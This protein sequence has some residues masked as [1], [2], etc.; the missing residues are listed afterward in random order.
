MSPPAGH[1][2][3]RSLATVARSVGR[4][5][6]L[7]SMIEVAAEEAAKAV[8][9]ASVSISRFEPNTHTVRVLINV[10]ELA[11]GE[12]RWPEQEVYRMED[13][14][15]LRTLVGELRMWTAALDDPASDPAEI[16]LLKS[17][18]KSSSMGAPLVVDGELWG[19]LYMTRVRGSDPF[20]DDDM[21]YAE[22]LAAIL[23]GALSRALHVDALSRLAYRD[24][25]TGL[26]NRRAFDEAIGTAFDPIAGRSG[27]RVSVVALDLNGLKA[28]NDRHGHNAGDQLLT[29]IAALLDAR[30]S[31]FPGSVVARVGGDEFAVLVPGHG[32]GG[33]VTAA[34]EVC[35][36][37][38]QL[39]LGSGLACG[40]ATTSR[41]ERV[42]GQ[43]LV[44]A[45]D[46]AQYTA[47]RRGLTTPVAAAAPYGYDLDPPMSDR[48]MG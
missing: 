23:A 15:Q 46:L 2:R 5:A 22:A 29:S 25:L 33:V 7:D 28:V 24:A 37:A 11:A 18:G 30:F 34:E 35:V 26:A 16:Q 44:N 36:A 12:S 32:L 48:S 21:A 6:R 42:T 10:G 39:L 41:S 31:D 19:E 20:D 40:I 45:A 13:F 1:A 38:R 3:L 14:E 43:Q 8:L 4:S 27:R 17:L 9:A 47:K